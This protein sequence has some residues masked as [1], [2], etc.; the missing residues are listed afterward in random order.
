MRNRGGCRLR[1]E[2]EAEMLSK[3]KYFPKKDGEKM[4]KKI[5]LC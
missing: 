3:R 5:I 2:M 1:S 4:L